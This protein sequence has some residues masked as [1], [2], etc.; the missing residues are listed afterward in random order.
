M[1]WESTLLLISLSPSPCM[2]S[3]PCA[4]SLN[5]SDQR[6][7]SESAGCL[8]CR[9]PDYLASYVAAMKKLQEDHGIQALVTGVHGGCTAPLQACVGSGG[10]HGQR[11]SAWG[12]MCA[13]VKHCPRTCLV[14]AVRQPHLKRCGDNKTHR[15]GASAL[16]HCSSNH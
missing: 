2:A 6:L 12:G 4:H 13:A 3:S 14:A 16:F 5:M 1:G 8:L 10:Q 7:T 11:G 15:Q 9:G